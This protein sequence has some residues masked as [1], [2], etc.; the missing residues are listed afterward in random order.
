MKGGC[1]HVREVCMD[2]RGDV[3]HK[4]HTRALGAIKEP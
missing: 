2:E 1:I 4:V 3:V